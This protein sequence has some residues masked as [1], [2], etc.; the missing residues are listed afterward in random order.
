MSKYELK[1]TEEIGKSCANCDR[2]AV[3]EEYHGADFWNYFCTE[4]CRDDYESSG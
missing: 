4:E 2:P 3:L 1:A